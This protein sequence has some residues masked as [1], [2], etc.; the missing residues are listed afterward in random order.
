MEERLFLGGS[1]IVFADIL[2]Q[3]EHSELALF[4]AQPRRSAREIWQDPEAMMTVMM[5][6]RIKTHLHARRPCVPS[7]LLVI[8][9]VIRPPNAPDINDPE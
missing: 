8:P 5:P 2:L 6:S 7:M 1:P 9:A 3:P 4:L